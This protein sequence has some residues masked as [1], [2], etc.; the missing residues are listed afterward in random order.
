[1]AA[2]HNRLYLSQS[3]YKVA[4]LYENPSDDWSAEQHRLVSEVNESFCRAE[5][6]IGRIKKTR[7]EESG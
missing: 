1:M 7:L 2:Q 6:A 3:M 5:G 4:F